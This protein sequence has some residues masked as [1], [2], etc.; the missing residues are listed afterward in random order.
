M[1]ELEFAKLK[2]ISALS[3]NLCC[4]CFEF[5]YAEKR[6]YIIPEQA[7]KEKLQAIKDLGSKLTELLEKL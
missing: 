6:G 3:R 7:Q 5:T 1:N 4:N 2:E